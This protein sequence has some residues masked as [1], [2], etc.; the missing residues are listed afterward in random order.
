M[1]PF[2]V[3]E[4]AGS[5]NYNVGLTLS[6]TFENKIKLKCFTLKTIANNLKKHPK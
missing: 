5:S 2:V 6:S 1:C 4:L 3:G